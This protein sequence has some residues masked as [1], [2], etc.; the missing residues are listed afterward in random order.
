M[1]KHFMALVGG[2]IGAIL[3]SVAY[4][5]LYTTSIGVI[6]MDVIIAAH[7]RSEGT[8]EFSTDEVDKSASA[9]NSALTESIQSI[10]AKYNVNLFVS[11]AIVSDAP[12]YTSLVIEEIQH[13]LNENG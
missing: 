6:Q 12:D 11:P 7:I 9:F 3:F 5:V 4:S 13:R 2:V 8:I 1:T 10:S